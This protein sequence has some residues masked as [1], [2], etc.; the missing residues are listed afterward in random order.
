MSTFN[1]A[2]FWPVEPPDPD[3]S[4]VKAVGKMIYYGA[5]VAVGE[6]DALPT[7]PPPP[8]YYDA[9]KLILVAWEDAERIK[10]RLHGFLGCLQLCLQ[11]YLYEVVE[12]GIPFLQFALEL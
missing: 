10:H 11:D 3:V 2:E 5:D 6:N 9:V 1:P 4:F 8:D 7:E 12:L